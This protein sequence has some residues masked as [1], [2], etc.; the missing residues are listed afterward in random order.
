MNPTARR[1]ARHYALQALYQWVIGGDTSREI[2]EQF[3]AHQITKDLDMP[4]F[5]ELI[6]AVPE[7]HLELDEHMKP[8]LKRPIKELDPIEQSILRLSVY[9]LT[10]RLDIP[11]RVV[12]NEA[13]ELTKKF[14]SV[15]GFK[16]VNGV[17][18]QVARKTRATEVAADA[19]KKHG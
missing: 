17:L 9:E 15:E 3:I 19:K 7:K 13:L 14:G 10:Y 18:D 12:I 5:K 8:F 6:H 16:F 4:Y 11:Y 1:H 2:E